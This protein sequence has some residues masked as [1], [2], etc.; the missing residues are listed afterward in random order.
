MAW[1]VYQGQVKKLDKSPEDKLAVISSER[2]LHDF[3]FVEFF[4]DLCE[5]DKNMI[6]RNEVQYF[7]PW[8]SVWN[9][10]SLST[11][12]R[13]V[14]DASQAG[15]TGVSLNSLLA[16]GINSMNRLVEILIRWTMHEWAF[17]TDIQKMYNAIR[18]DKSHWCYEMYL[19]DNE[20]DKER[21]PS[22]KVIKTLIYGVKSSGSQAERGL[23]LTAEKCVLKY[24]RACQIIDSE[25][26]VYCSE[27]ENVDKGKLRV[28]Q[29]G[30]A[31]LQTYATSCG[32]HLLSKY[33]NENENEVVIHPNCQKQVT[34]ELRKYHKTPKEDNAKV[35]CLSITP[36]SSVPDFD[37]RKNCLFCSNPCTGDKRYQKLSDYSE[38]ETIEFRESLLK[39]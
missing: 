35:P 28:V 18:L 9:S 2:K 19:W 27:A 16:K 15:K 7:I 6:L 25:H 23:R 39:L 26:S 30:I 11:P 4:N 38:C 12:C 10:I 8:R 13:L 1:K 3:G 32:L 14:L 17:N 24:P 20:L 21:L 29:S 37:W 31:R 34:N 22:W 5:N 33:L 36:R